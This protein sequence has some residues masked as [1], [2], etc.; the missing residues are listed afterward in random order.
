MIDKKTGAQIPLKENEPLEIFHYSLDTKQ[1][2]NIFNADK[3]SLIFFF[4]KLFITCLNYFTQKFNPRFNF[5][6]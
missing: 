4:Y 2:E 6:I 3:T 1:E 5:G